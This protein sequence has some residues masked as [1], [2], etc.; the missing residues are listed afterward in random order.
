MDPAQLEQY[1]VELAWLIQVNRM[2]QGRP[3]L[4]HYQI[5]VTVC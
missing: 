4:E 2:C 1:Y 3:L 5:Q